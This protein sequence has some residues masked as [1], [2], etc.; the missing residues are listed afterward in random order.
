[1]PLSRYGDVRG[2]TELQ[3]YFKKSEGLTV[4]ELL[5]AQTLANVPSGSLDFIV[6]AHVIGHLEDPVSSI[7]RGLNRLRLGGRYL[8]PAP[9]KRLTSDRERSPRPLE[10]LLVDAT[11]GGNGTGLEAYR[12]FIRDTAIAEWGDPLAPIE[13]DGR[14]LAAEGVDIH[15]HVWMGRR[16]TTC[17]RILPRTTISKHWKVRSR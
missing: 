15:F 6:S 3:Q 17:F 10:R 9:D 4:T 5:D 2:Q 11:D 1:L 13:A 14:R 12:D 7:L 8:L 16:S